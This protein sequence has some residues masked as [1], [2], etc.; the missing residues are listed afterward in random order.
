[1]VFRLRTYEVGLLCRLDFDL[2]AGDGDTNSVGYFAFHMFSR[3][4]YGVD[5]ST[6]DFKSF[7]DR[8]FVGVRVS[9]W[10]IL[11]ITFTHTKSVFC[12]ISGGDCSD[13]CP[14]KQRGCVFQGNCW[15]LRWW[16]DIRLDLRKVIL[17][18]S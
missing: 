14:C 2:Y 11:F 5:C 1:M 6:D 9:G 17:C 12:A 15:D 18:H 13:G 8:A 10:K 3:K 16:T 4:R 7:Y